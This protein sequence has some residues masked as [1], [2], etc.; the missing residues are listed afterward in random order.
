MSGAQTQFVLGVEGAA[1]L[2]NMFNIHEAEFRRIYSDIGYMQLARGISAYA[3]LQQLARPSYIHAGAVDNLGPGMA[4]D[5]REVK[6]GRKT[7]AFWLRYIHTHT[8]AHT[9]THTHAHAQVKKD[10]KTMALWLRYMRLSACAYGVHFM[11]VTG[12]CDPHL[13]VMGD[14]AALYERTGIAQEK[15]IHVVWENEGYAAPAWLLVQDDLT[16]AVCLVISVYMHKHILSRALSLSRTHTRKHTHT[17][18]QGSKNNSD[19][20]SNLRCANVDVRQV[21]FASIVGLFLSNN[22]PLLQKT[23][24]GVRQGD[25]FGPGIALSE[26]AHIL[27]VCAVAYLP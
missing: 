27:K 4:G 26:E 11:T 23:N 20:L 19:W 14:A 22:R 9:H 1:I 12:V 18:K 21:S 7:A 25:H 8:L 16:H 24:E 10:S 13:L 6:N 15:I 17:H 2:E 5:A 3:C